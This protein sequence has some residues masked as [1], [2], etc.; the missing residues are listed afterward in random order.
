LRKTVP[1]TDDPLAEE[2][3]PEVKVSLLTSGFLTIV[4]AVIDT[5][6][7]RGKFSFF[8]GREGRKGK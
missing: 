1:S 5:P 7:Y 4:Q 2:I 8:R 6:R 3:L